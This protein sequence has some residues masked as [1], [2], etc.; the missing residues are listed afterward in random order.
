M[1]QRHNERSEV[2]VGSGENKGIGQNWKAHVVER[3]VDTHIP[4]QAF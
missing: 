1:K 2:T 3:M 4:K